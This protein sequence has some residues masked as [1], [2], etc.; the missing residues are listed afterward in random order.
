VLTAVTAVVIRRRL[1][2]AYRAV[3]DALPAG[4]NHD[5]NQ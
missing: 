2:R 4:D 1:T 3:L 5:R